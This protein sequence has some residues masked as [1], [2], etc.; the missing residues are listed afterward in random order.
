MVW[1]H[2]DRNVRSEILLVAAVRLAIAESVVTVELLGGRLID[3]WPKTV[4]QINLKEKVG[5]EIYQPNDSE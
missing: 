4:S 5:R 3:S 1:A 2:Q